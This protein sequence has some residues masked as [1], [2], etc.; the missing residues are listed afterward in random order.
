M[1]PFW[2]RLSK[3]K[4]PIFST[5]FM[6][7]MNMNMTVNK[8]HMSI[9]I[10][11]LIHVL[12]CWLQFP[13]NAPTLQEVKTLYR[14]NLPSLQNPHPKLNFFITTPIKSL[15]TQTI[16]RVS[17][18]SHPQF[19]SKVRGDNVNKKTSIFTRRITV[20][21]KRNSLKSCKKKTYSW[22]RKSTS[23]TPGSG[24]FSMN[25]I[26]SNTHQKLYKTLIQII[27]KIHFKSQTTTLWNSITHGFRK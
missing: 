24:K 15:K 26:K 25:S 16:Q 11:N 21:R 23:Y 13:K 4:Q 18:I 6:S 10:H 12:H 17:K 8:T 14:Q 22:R 2:M 3:Y 27:V 1:T 5:M 20:K 9:L 7:S 19:L